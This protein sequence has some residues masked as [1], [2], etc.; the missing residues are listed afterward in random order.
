MFTYLETLAQGQRRLQK[1]YEK[2]DISSSDADVSK[3]D[4]HSQNDP[5]PEILNDGN[6]EEVLNNVP[7]IDD[8]RK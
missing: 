7:L 5:E 4:G 2:E 6:V 8:L 1:S 3:N